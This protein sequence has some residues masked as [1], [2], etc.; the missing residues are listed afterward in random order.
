MGKFFRRL[1]GLVYAGP[2]HPEEVDLN[3]MSAVYAGPEYFEA[4]KM[5]ADNVDIVEVYAG[6]AMPDD[7]DEKINPMLSDMP[8]YPAQFEAKEEIVCKVCGT[9]GSGKFCLNCGAFL[10][11]KNDELQA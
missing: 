6:P 9:K 1:T 7:E 11:K 8:T 3:R 10:E 2:K 4:L 5:K